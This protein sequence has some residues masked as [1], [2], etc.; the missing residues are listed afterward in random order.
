MEWYAYAVPVALVVVVILPLLLIFC[1]P[2]PSVTPSNDSHPP[3]SAKP[4]ID[5]SPPPLRRTRSTSPRKAATARQDLP[6]LTREA[7]RN[8]PGEQPVGPN[9]SG[10]GYAPPT[11]LE[12][13]AAVALAS[14]RPKLQP[15][16]EIVR[17]RLSDVLKITNTFDQSRRIGRGSTSEVFMATWTSGDTWAVKRSQHRIT[18]AELQA[19]GGNQMQHLALAPDVEERL[20]ELARR[21]NGH[22]NL[23]H[24]GG[25]C[26]E[27]RE[28]I[29]ALEFVKGQTLEALLLPSRSR[30][31]SPAKKREEGDAAIGAHT[32]SSR[33]GLSFL[34]RLSVA[35]QI[36]DAVSFLHGDVSSSSSNDDSSHVQQGG[37]GDSKAGSSDGRVAYIHQNLHPKNVHITDDLMVKVGNPG[38]LKQLLQ[39]GTD[40]KHRAGGTFSTLGFQSPGYIDPEYHLTGVV[41]IAGD[42]FSFGVILLQM[43]T[44]QR[45]VVDTS[46]FPDAPPAEASSED[47]RSSGKREG[48]I[49][50]MK[51]I[52]MWARPYIR[53][54]VVEPIVDSRLGSEY[55]SSAMRVL[56]ELAL[57]CQKVPAIRR[58]TMKDIS[59]KIRGVLRDE[60][61]KISGM[62]TID[63]PMA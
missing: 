5:Y 27:E 14:S 25:Y 31:G 62:V 50:T 60:A 9:N 41:T 23:V 1:R 59:L 24:V 49:D 44:G 46:A 51:S 32:S 11:A 61:S 42:V 2:R 6:T 43:L 18:D 53:K 3:S 56:M 20:A 54:G 40:V 47:E 36:A 34:Q 21:L 57:E 28:R 12:L 15:A 55:G 7:A 38:Q 22:H 63:V 19:M 17:L 45:A 13:A 35:S 48:S 29:V 52:G 37:E 4:S 33:R 58:P 30:D 16:S 8:L 39:E 10:D 26:F